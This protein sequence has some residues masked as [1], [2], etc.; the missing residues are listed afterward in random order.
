MQERE[1]DFT[2]TGNGVRMAGSDFLVW[3][4]AHVLGV[5]KA[6]GAPDLEARFEVRDGV[7]ECTEFTLRSKPGGRAVRTADLRLFDMD[8]FTLHVFTRKGAVL[9]KPEGTAG[10]A[11]PLASEREWWA[12]NAAVA[13][14]QRGRR[15]VSRW[16]LEEVARIYNDNIHGT[17]S[18]TS[19]A[20]GPT[21]AV[22]Q[23][24]RLS[25]RTAARRVQQ[26]RDAGLLPPTTPGRKLGST[27]HESD[28][29]QE[30]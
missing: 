5:D 6:S 20:P 28:T 7:P 2:Y 26:A 27:P 29:G 30:Q 1:V 18:A 9:K 25:G 22:E 14:A 23:A 4:E 19:P 16:E 24:L 11:Q 8:G 10:A 12:A 15:S 13:E 21:K 3:S 17:S